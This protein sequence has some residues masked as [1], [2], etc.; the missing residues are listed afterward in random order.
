MS[1]LCIYIRLFKSSSLAEDALELFSDESYKLENFCRN[2]F[3]IFLKKN[4]KI[5][6]NLYIKL[7]ALVINVLGI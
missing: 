1:R 5:H 4:Y 7:A 3:T 2:Y 6:E